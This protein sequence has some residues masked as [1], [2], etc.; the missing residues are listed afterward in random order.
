MFLIQKPQNGYAVW[1]VPFYRNLNCKH[2]N[3]RFHQENI[4][5]F[6]SQI[7][8]LG[9]IP[10]GLTIVQSWAVTSSSEPLPLPTASH[11]PPFQTFSFLTSRLEAFETLFFL[12]LFQPFPFVELPHPSQTSSTITML[13]CKPDESLAGIETGLDCEQLRPGPHNFPIQLNLIFNSQACLTQHI[14][15]PPLGFPFLHH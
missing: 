5:G 7:E 13:S 6:C 4:S 1:P 3:I 2:L 8:W 15:S 12:H 11:F 10:E 14:A 9:S